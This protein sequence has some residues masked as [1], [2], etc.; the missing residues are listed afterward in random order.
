M[1][2]A[3]EL[4]AQAKAE[5][6]A[7]RLVEAV[8]LYEQ[9]LQ[10][11]ARH[12]EAHNLLGAALGQQGNLDAA[13]QHFQEAHALS[14]NAPD[15]AHNLHQTVAYRE[16]TRGNALAAQGRA[17][18]A[19]ACF[20]RA[21]EANPDY[22]E[23]LTNLGA[24]QA[25]QG[26]LAAAVSNH[27]RA[28]ELRPTFVE[29]HNNLG[30][31]L[32]RLKELD[33]AEAS[34]RRALELNPSHSKAHNNLGAALL[35]QK[36][37]AEAETCCRRALELRPDFAEAHNTLACVLRDADRLDEAIASCRRALELRPD[38]AESRANFA[39]ILVRQERLDEAIAEYRRVLEQKT[40]FAEVHLNLGVVLSD[41]GQFVEAADH[42]RRTLELKPACA[43]AHHNHGVM[44]LQ[45][46]LPVEALASFRQ[47]LEIDP[48]LASAHSCSLLAA[49]YQ[50]DVSLAQLA[51][52]HREFGDRHAIARF[53]MRSPENSREPDRPLRLGFL[54]PDLSYHPVGYFLAGVLENLA[55]PELNATC[56]NDRFQA[57][58]MADR[59]QAAADSWRNVR[60]LSDAQLAEQIRDDRID[61]LFDL[62]GHT[63]SNRL[64]MFAARPAPL[65]IT[66]MGYVGTTGLKAIDY[67]LADRYHV[68][69][70]AEPFIVEQVL[71]MPDGYV[72]YVPPA[73]A[74]CVSP[75][76]ALARGH[77]TFG[78]FNNPVKIT[79]QVIDV[80]VDILRRVPSARLVLKYRWLDVPLVMDRIARQFSERGIE[81]SRLDLLGAT[82]HA[83]LLEHYQGIDIALDPFP[84]SGGAT[85]CEALWMGVPVMTCPGET[86][87]SRHSLSHLSN[88]GL[89]ETI[90]ADLVAYSDLAVAMAHDLTQLAELRGRLRDQMAASPLCDGPRFACGFARV[91]RSAW[92]T[93]CGAA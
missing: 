27:R 39:S 93:W 62:A 15:I 44:F 32:L 75:L 21:L 51:A 64:P 8:R 2:T 86:F 1:A 33:A 30:A 46:G 40:D 60:P 53:V 55:R 79:P 28:I 74:P 61:I 25:E 50:T 89:T 80:W 56:Y 90:A 65:Q 24:A 10:L 58:A 49:Q 82:S 77:V 66:W 87:A 54:S 84:Y 59:L 19:A 57:D 35:Q 5:H 23:A 72:C 36:R 78:S 4:L 70:A 92:R 48:L 73:Y 3:S 45:Q 34:L 88:V 76:P 26:E 38:D 16:N 63:G 71:R 31:A 37:L 85:T 67:L 20:R 14:P 52:A 43:D 9:V 13:I 91:L 69:A 11:D 41:R 18:E 6:G 12:A 7:G 42:W 83:N 47:A 22:I 17:A 81:R 29:A 68:P